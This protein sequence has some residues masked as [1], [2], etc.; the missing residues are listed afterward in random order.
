MSKPELFMM[1]AAVPVDDLKVK[2][3]PGGV[4]RTLT[5][6]IFQQVID[7]MNK[8]DSQQRLKDHISDPLIRMLYTQMFPYVMVICAVMLIILLTSL[9]TC[10]M[11]AMFFFKSR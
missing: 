1:S 3:E 8:P 9:C 7:E 2:P 6:R 10:T 4:V 5:H 11:F